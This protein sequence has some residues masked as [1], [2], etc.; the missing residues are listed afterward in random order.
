M[1]WISTLELLSKY[2]TTGRKHMSNPDYTSTQEP[3]LASSKLS[4]KQNIQEQREIHYYRDLD[5][6]TKSL[7]VDHSAS[8]VSACE[9][10]A[11]KLVDI[12]R[13]RVSLANIPPALRVEVCQ[14]SFRG[15]LRT[16]RL[17]EKGSTRAQHTIKKSV[18]NEN[19]LGTPFLS[20]FVRDKV[21]M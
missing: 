21:H 15:S 10:H 17:C 6:V 12:S 9:N 8:A 14:S 13:C 16:S 19:D 4:W 7:H 1:C 18:Q 11:L 20:I 3:T 2:L 5:N